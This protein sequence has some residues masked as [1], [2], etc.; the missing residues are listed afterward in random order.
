MVAKNCV[1]HNEH[2][3]TTQVPYRN[4]SLNESGK[5]HVATCNG[6]YPPHVFILDDE[7]YTG[8]EEPETILRLG[9]LDK[10]LRICV[11]EGISPIIAIQ[12]V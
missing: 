3:Y 7:N 10:H 12:R 9:H 5:L 6:G 8:I 2:I 4:I 1:E 11:E